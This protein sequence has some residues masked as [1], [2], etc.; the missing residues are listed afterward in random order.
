MEKYHDKK[1]ANGKEEIGEGINT[2]D[3][4][5]KNHK[6]LL[7]R[8]RLSMSEVQERYGISRRQRMASNRKFCTAKGTRFRGA[9]WLLSLSV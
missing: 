9:S 1:R 5:A 6:K 4:K 2:Q 8:L 7:S 3:T